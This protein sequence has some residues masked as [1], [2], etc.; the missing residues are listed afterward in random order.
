MKMSPTVITYAIYAFQ[1]IVIILLI[2]KT[3]LEANSS[4]SKDKRIEELEDI[5]RDVQDTISQK[6]PIHISYSVSLIPNSLLTYKITFQN[7]CESALRNVICLFHTIRA[8][9]IRDGNI[10]SHDVSNVIRTSPVEGSSYGDNST[11]QNGSIAVRGWKPNQDWDVFVDLEAISDSR[12]NKTTQVDSIHFQINMQWLING[13]LSEPSTVSIKIN[14]D[15]N[16]YDIKPQLGS[17]VFP[18]KPL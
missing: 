3:H 8:L 1:A 6:P 17:F 15:S 7:D 11:N 16:T 13:I 2:Y 4:R 12:L 14:L 9:G 5:A 10:V 18:E